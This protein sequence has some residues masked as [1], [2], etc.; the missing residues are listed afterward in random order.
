MDK[1]YQVFVSSTYTDLKD[2]RQEVIKALLELDCFPASMEFFPSTDDDQWTLIKQ[3]IDDCDYYIVIIGG[4]YGSLSS[5]G[6]S[7]TEKEYRYALETGKPIIA[8][9]HEDPDSLPKNKSELNPET[10][11]KLEEFKELVQKKMC[12][13]WKDAVDLGS[14]VSRSFIK[15]QK[16]HP[17]IGWVKGNLV[18]EKDSSIEILELKR[19]IERL[20]QQLEDAKTKAPKGSENLA[21]GDDEVTLKYICKL[22]DGTTF[23]DSYLNSS[24]NTTWNDIFA[25]IAPLLISEMDEWQM[26]ETLNRLIKKL[27]IETLKNNKELKGYK[28]KSFEI[29]EDDYQTIKVQLRALGLMVQSDKKRAVSDKKTYWTLTPYGD[30]VMNQLRAIKREQ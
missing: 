15:L 23:Y 28:I 5:E 25:Q 19:E 30:T 4:R 2:E 24:V 12:K 13:Y 14:V 9:L 6:I 22:N 20:K 16:S 1:K 11:N 7:Y 8:F 27:C 17:A 21:K 3:V 29:N 10:S 18:P 26:R